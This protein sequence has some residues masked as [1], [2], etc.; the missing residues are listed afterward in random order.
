MT[1]TLTALL[2]LGTLPK[3][4]I[5]AEPG[6]AIHS[7]SPVTI[8]CQGTPGAKEY[9]LEKE[10]SPRPL[11]RQEQLEPGDRAKFSIT[12]MTERDAGR[13]GCLYRSPAGWS[14]HSD[15]LELVMV[16]GSYSKPSL[17]ALPSP[18]VPSGGNVT[19][20]CGTW[21][22]FDIFILTKE[23]DHRL[24]WALDSQY[25]SGKTQA[26]F[27]V[28][29]V[30]ASYWWAFRCYGCQRDRPHVWSYPSEP[31]ELLVSGESGKPSL[32][33]QQGPIVASGQNLTLQCRSDVGYDRFALHKEGKQDLLQSLVLQPQAG[34]SQAHFPLDT[35]S[36]SYGG[37]YRCYG[38]YNL[39]SEWSAPSDPLDILVAGWLTD[40]PSLSVQ[41]GP[42]VAS[43]ENV[44]LR[45]Q[46]QSQRDTFL[47]SKERAADPP[48]SLKS[49]HRAQQYQAEF[50]MSPV[51]SAHGGTYRCYSSRSSSPFLLSHPSEPLELLVSGDVPK[52]SIWADPG[53]IV[54]NGS[55]V[56]I[57]CQGSLQASAYVLYKERGSEP[58]ETKKP[59]ESSG[60]AGFLIGTTT[61]SHAG[62]YQCAYYT[63][64][65]ILSEQS[66]PLL[67]VV[68]GFYGAPSLSAQPGP[69]VASGEIVSLS[70]SSLFTSGPFHLFKEGGADPNLHMVAEPRNHA[71][72]WQAIFPV[73]PVRPTHGGTYRCYGSPS[74]NPNLW[75]Q[76][77]APLH[78]EVTASKPQ[79]Y[80]VEN[81]IRMGMAGLV[82]V[83][84]GVLLFQARNDTRMT[85]HAAKM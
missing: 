27:P 17:S 7:G 63:I 81:L 44:T 33:T 58:W 85:H 54:T 64:G 18:I 14:E 5:W 73:G 2:C 8:W 15:S 67:L 13:Y 3:P 70:C 4:T 59:Q 34:L 38:G 80:T 40:R 35:V 66:D 24:S 78:I 37:R 25:A 29:P 16:T 42:S 47:L 23:G 51:T 55:S 21:E 69:V 10:R 50:P 26:L 75:S 36:S 39:S 9:H 11:K 46:S 72:T 60:K 74:S 62:Q 79:D 53:P 1:P 6:S 28:G 49:E 48:L 57:W 30:T 41:P 77:S 56:T 71:G 45:C 68:T 12:Y 43:G 32:L 76:P 65:N 82:L 61:S 20:Q 52:P 84:L 19:L 31:L 22:R 83:V